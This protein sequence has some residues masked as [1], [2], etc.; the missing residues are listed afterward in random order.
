MSLVAVRKG[1]RSPDLAMVVFL[2][3]MAC[4]VWVAYTRSLPGLNTSG[5][6]VPDIRYLSPLHLP[7]G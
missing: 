3:V 5:G 6:I 4:A 7:V 1:E 2:A